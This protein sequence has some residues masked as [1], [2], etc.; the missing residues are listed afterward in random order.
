M[1]VVVTNTVRV[2]TTLIKVVRAHAPQTYSMRTQRIRDFEQSSW[3]TM[4]RSIRADQGISQRQLALMANVS[5]NA[6]RR[7]ENQTGPVTMDFMERIL[8][9]LGYELDIF[10]VVKTIEDEML[11]TVR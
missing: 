2:R 1:V 8:C 9:A 3:G 7:M 11:L 6:L 10:P 5:R 4:L